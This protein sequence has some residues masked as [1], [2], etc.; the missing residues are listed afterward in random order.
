MRLLILTVTILNSPGIDCYLFSDFQVVSVLI[1]FRL[2]KN[3]AGTIFVTFALLTKFAKIV[4]VKLV[5][6]RYFIPG[7]MAQPCSFTV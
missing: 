4:P 3:F 5:T 1:T 7:L 2:Y 6:L